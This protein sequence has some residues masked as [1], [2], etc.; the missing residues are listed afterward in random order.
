MYLCCIKIKGTRGLQ[1][2]FALQELLE[3]GQIVKTFLI[4]VSSF[5]GVW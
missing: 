5:L 4:L 2:L 1:S 3:L